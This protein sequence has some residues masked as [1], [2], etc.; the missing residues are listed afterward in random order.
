MV[1][2]SNC[3]LR[4]LPVRGDER[5]SL[6]ALEVESDLPFTIERVYYIF[7]TQPGVDRGFHAHHNLLQWVICVAGSCVMILD[8]GRQRREYVLNRPDLALQIGPMIW[9]EMRDFA[10]GTV[11][12]VLASRRYSEADYIRDYA[13]F[14]T[15][16]TGAKL[17]PDS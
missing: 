5:G 8:D 13:T 17:D 4:H 14:V 12:M 6:I 15:L 9:R 10:P 11:L 1:A 16:A 2:F 3:G 7:D